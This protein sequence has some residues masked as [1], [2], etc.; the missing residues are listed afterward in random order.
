MKRKQAGDGSS[1]Q[2]VLEMAAVIPLMAL[3]LA[4]AFAFGPLVYVK[5]AVQQAAYDCA[6][7]A[8]QSLDSATGMRQGAAAGHRSLGAFSLDPGGA[9]IRVYGDWGRSGS[10]GCAIRCRIA[11]GAF[12]F[13]GLVP[14]PESLGHAVTITPQVNKSM[15]R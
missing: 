3:L 11:A 6:I 1:G 13:H 4:A 12:P 15:W 14:I 9:D 8:A 5:I 10:V 2:A 7:S